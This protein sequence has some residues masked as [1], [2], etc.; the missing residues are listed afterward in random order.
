[1]P[2]H[3]PSSAAERRSG[4]RRNTNVETHKYAMVRC[5]AY[6]EDLLTL[7]EELV[8]GGRQGSGMPQCP[9]HQRHYQESCRAYS[10]AKDRARQRRGMIPSLED[11]YGMTDASFVEE[12]QQCVKMYLEALR[13]EREGRKLHA[14]RFF[15]SQM[16]EGHMKRYENVK[17]EIKRAEVLASAL[18]TRKR[19]IMQS[20]VYARSRATAQTRPHY[21]DLP[22]PRQANN[23]RQRYYS[24]ENHPRNSANGYSQHAHPT[25]TPSATRNQSSGYH[26]SVPPRKEVPPTAFH[27]SRE[28]NSAYNHRPENDKDDV[29]DEPGA[30]ASP[31][32]ATAW[33]VRAL[34]GV[35]FVLWMRGISL[36]QAAKAI[37]QS[38]ANLM[39]GH[40]P[41]SA[42]R[43]FDP[44][45]LF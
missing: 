19:F 22:L 7:C 36:K 38:I 41:S 17:R 8:K 42:S 33:G 34:L 44:F 24:A 12:K 35:A 45:P 6:G 5:S 10:D 21:H 18:G 11:I 2:R 9:T 15:N 4:A 27:R 43:I 40:P 29:P 3:G 1:M 31:L 28:W 26:T 39:F 32:S 14:N 37:S 20:H 25:T 13:E 23:E 30:T 16:D